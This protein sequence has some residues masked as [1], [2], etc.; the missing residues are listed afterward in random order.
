MRELEK[1]GFEVGDFGWAGYDNFY[2]EGGFDISAEHGDAYKYIDY[3]GEFRGGYPYISEEIQQ[4][5]EDYGYIL[6]WY[7]AGVLQA[8]PDY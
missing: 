8:S 6:E 1:M 2:A 5:A 7:N 3:Y 4:M